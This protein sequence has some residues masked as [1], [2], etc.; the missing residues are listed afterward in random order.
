MVD[1]HRTE[2]FDLSLFL[3]EQL[4][5]MTITKNMITQH[6]FIYLFIPTTT[7]IHDTKISL[8]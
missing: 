6:L 2:I 8:L 4:I 3:L 1:K 5:R 7:V